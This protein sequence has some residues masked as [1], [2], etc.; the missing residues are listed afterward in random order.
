M[1]IFLASFSRTV[2]K[3]TLDYKLAGAFFISIVFSLLILLIEGNEEKEFSF[4]KNQQIEEFVKKIKENKNAQIAMLLVVIALFFFTPI[5]DVFLGPLRVSGYTNPLQKTIAEQGAAG[6]NFVGSLGFFGASEKQLQLLALLSPISSIFNLIFSTV[7]ALLANIFHI[8]IIYSAKDAHLVTTTLLIFIGVAAY[9]LYLM[10]F[11][12]EDHTIWLLLSL[13][14]I[15]VG[16][17]GLVKAKYTIYLGFVL[18]YAL[19]SLFFELQRTFKLYS[20]GVLALVLLLALAEAGAVYPLGSSLLQNAF[21]VRFQENPL[22]LQPRFSSLCNE[23]QSFGQKDELVCNVASDPVGYANKGIN[24]Q[25]NSRLCQY[26]FIDP[27]K[28]YTKEDEQIDEQYAA[29]VRCQKLSDYWIDV[30]DWIRNNTEEN[31]TI[32]SWWDYGHW[33]NYFGMRRT[34][35]RNEHSSE[36]MIEATAYHFIMGDENSLIKYMRD[37]YSEYLM[38]DKEIVMAGNSFGGKYGALNYLACSYAN[39][40]N[41]SFNP[42]QSLCERNNL[43]ETI[44]V[45]T[46]NKEPCTISPTKQG[47][48]AYKITS[49]GLKPTYCLGTAN[50]LG[51]DIPATYYLDKVNEDGSLKL[52]KAFLQQAG[53]VKGYTSYVLLYTKDKVWP[54]VTELLVVGRTEKEDSMIQ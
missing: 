17:I 35:I 38:L 26:S 43:W 21:V 6:A 41:V 14:V 32:I 31:A 40:T 48:I 45:P 27:I 36:K 29:S 54:S 8:Q 5:S 28:I 2:V 33:T 9:K 24:E 15:P 47:T 37:H 44:Y 12:N 13:L 18:T 7:S 22:A 50:V 49:T 4:L 10:F 16:L 39:Q 25:Y 52:N 23:F 1:G 19:A 53:N 3:L 20:A 30:M 46:M 51:R 34:V 11:K 42:G